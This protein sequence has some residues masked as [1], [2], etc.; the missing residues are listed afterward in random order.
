[1]IETIPSKSSIKSFP[2]YFNWS[3]NAECRTQDTDPKIIYD[4]ETEY[5][6]KTPSHRYM[7]RTL[8]GETLS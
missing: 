4:R 3:Q 8:I 2:Y 5:L 7:L 6:S 1:M